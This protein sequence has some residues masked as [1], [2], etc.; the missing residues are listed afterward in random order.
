MLMLV[1]FL[2]GLLA[3]TVDAI[4]GGGGLIT[5]P[6]LLSIGL[7]PHVAF[8]TNKLQG[9]IGTS[10]AARRFWKEGWISLRG[11]Y[12]GV[13]AGLVGAASGAIA[14]QM[15]D[16]TVLKHIVPALLMLIFLYTMFSPRLGDNDIAP[17]MN[18]W[19][20]YLLFGFVLGFYDGFFGPG[21]GAFWVFALMFFLGFNLVKATAYTKVFNLNSSLIALVCFAVGSNI[22][23]RVGLCMA[24]GQVIGGWLGASLAINKGVRLIRP[25]FLTMVFLTI[26]SMIY[27]TYGL[28][29]MHLVAVSLHKSTYVPLVAGVL[30]VAAVLVIKRLHR[31]RDANLINT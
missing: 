28:S 24:A 27:R 4:A 11:I 31:G 8:G 19:L 23:Y 9:V 29:F 10:M 3:G 12:R 17:R 21:T 7:P 14:N 16:G 26:A 20:F 22:D 1:L 13:F 6:V 5:I 18:G 25:L 2:T 15:L 30:G